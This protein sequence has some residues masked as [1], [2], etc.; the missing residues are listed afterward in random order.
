[1]QRNLSPAAAGLAEGRSLISAEA[2]DSSRGVVSL[3]AQ[4]ASAGLFALAEN[5]EITASGDKTQA[6][7]QQPDH[8]SAVADRDAR[9]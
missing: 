6:P 3:L 8:R 2:H 9:S 4:A 1:M 7:W 5:S